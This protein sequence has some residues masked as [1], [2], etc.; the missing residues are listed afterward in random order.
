MIRKRANLLLIL[1]IYTPF[2]AESQE[3]ILSDVSYLYMEKLIAAAKENSPRNIVFNEQ[4][5]VAKNNLA[6]QK[7]SWLDPFSFSYIYRSNT[8]LDIVTADLLRGY[9]LSASI[10][11]GV[12]FKKPFMVKAARDQVQIAQAEKTEYDLQLESL[13]KQR[14]LAYLQNLNVLKLRTRIALDNE[15]TFK[16][17]RAKFERNEISFEDYNSVSIAV[18]SAYESKIIAEANLA[19]AKASLEEL[20]VKKLEEI[21]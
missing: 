11:P 14:Y 5:S 1:F 3:S 19:I 2:F 15:G 18:N 21:K 17:A 16:S 6:Q 4:I 20:T 7:T 13:V 8:T 12:F 9:Q 10:N